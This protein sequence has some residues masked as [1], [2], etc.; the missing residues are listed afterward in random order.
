[1][2]RRSVFSV[3]SVASCVWRVTDMQIT[4]EYTAQMK[5]AAGV[6]S[7]TLDVSEGMTLAEFIINLAD[8]RDESLGRHLLGSDGQPQPTVLAFRRD[9]Q[10][11]L[12]DPEPLR[13]GDV[14]TFLAPISGG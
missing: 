2:V 11:R 5:R 6:S 1:M 7:E 13:D 3:F 10:I 4:A 9:E 12:D 14:I 8:G